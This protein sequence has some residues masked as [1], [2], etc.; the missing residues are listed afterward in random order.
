[1]ILSS[2]RK[3][4]KLSNAVCD[5]SMTATVIIIGYTFAVI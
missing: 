5:Y 3:C 1:M 2:E 4:T